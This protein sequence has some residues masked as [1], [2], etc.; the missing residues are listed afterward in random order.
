MKSIFLIIITSTLSLITSAQCSLYE[1]EVQDSSVCAPQVI[2]FNVLNAPNNAT[3][4]WDI[5]K[6]ATSGADTIYGYYTAAELINAKV[7][8]K[9]PNGS[10][11]SLS[12]DSAL[13]VNS[14]PQPVFSV[15]RTK[16]C[17]GPDTLSL[18][19]LTPNI[20]TRNWVVD[21]TSYSNSNK[22]LIHSFV[23][24]GKKSISLITIDSNGCQ[25]VEE[26]KDF[27]EV[28]PNLKFDFEASLTKGC[29]PLETTF[30]LKIILK[31]LCK[32][33]ILGDFIM[34]IMSILA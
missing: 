21:G 30:K 7:E 27:V 32:K 14:K 1:I 19:D 4:L 34:Q 9:L 15:S 17:Y 26:Y 24:S 31:P 10:V 2:R 13:I 11:C 25:G 8:I 16:L 28:F 3:Y 6:G 33:H 29:V 12:R 22:S 18:I 23:T 20:R 5:G